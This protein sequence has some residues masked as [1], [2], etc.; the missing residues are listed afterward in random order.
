MFIQGDPAFEDL[1]AGRGGCSAGLNLLDSVDA[2]AVQRRKIVQEKLFF[3]MESV[4]R[5]W[6][7][8]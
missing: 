8:F 5:I 1:G 6:E 3:F 4:H 7:A 2:C